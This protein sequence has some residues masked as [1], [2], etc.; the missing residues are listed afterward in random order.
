MRIRRQD[1]LIY[2][3]AALVC[4]SLYYWLETTQ[5]A[6]WKL[7]LY[8]HARS[9]EIFYNLSMT[10]LEGI[11]Y[12]SVYPTFA[13]GSECMGYQF[14]LMMFAMHVCNFTGRFQTGCCCS[15]RLSNAINS[16]L[17]CFT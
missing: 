17:C 15:C 7:L 4:F 9:V 2:T 10:Y 5:G 16:G 13:I 1:L 6:V 3:A 14:I 8:P 12:Y 11:G